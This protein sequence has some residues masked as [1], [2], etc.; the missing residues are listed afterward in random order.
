MYEHGCSILYI[1]IESPI[2]CKQEASI[3]CINAKNQFLEVSSQG[4]TTL[5]STLAMCLHIYIW[6]RNY[7]QYRS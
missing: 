7:I 5:R 1:T 3:F 6:T 2:L 4:S